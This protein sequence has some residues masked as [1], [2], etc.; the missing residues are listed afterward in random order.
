M[1]VTITFPS[2]RKKNIPLGTTVEE[3]I[4]DE[5]F[6]SADSP[7]I[8]VMVNNDIASLTYR[9]EIDCRLAPIKLASR[10]GADIYRRSLC[11][12]LTI[13]A[14]GLFPDRRLVIGHSLGRGYFY[15]FDNIEEVSDRDLERIR[16][17][18]QEIV[19]TCLPI[20]RQVIPYLEAVQYFEINNQRDT[21]L[22]LKNRNDPKIAVYRCGE[23]IDLAHAPLVPNTGILKVFDILNYPPGFLLRY[24][25]WNKPSEMSPFKDDPVLFAIYREYKNWGKILNVNCVGLLNDLIHERRVKEFI[26]VAEALHDKKIAKIADK[27]SEK[28]EAVKIILIAGPS[29]SGKTTFSKKLSIQLKVLGRN[30]VSISHDD[31]FLPRELTP[32]DEEGNCDFESLNA[33]N[34]AL[35]NEHL[36]RLLQGEE[37]IIPRF[38]FH[39]GQRKESGLAL[40]LPKR[41]I[42]I[43]EGIH[44][45]ND[46]LTHLIEKDRKY[47]IYI[48]TLT[49]LNLDD[50]NR[51]STTDNRL[52]RRIV[53]DY[54]FRGHSA[55]DTLSMWQSVRNG[56]NRNIFPFQNTADSAFNSA[57]DYE[58]AVLKVYAEP[59]LKTVKPDQEVFYEAR[60]LLSFLVDFAPIPSSWVPEYSILREFIGESAFK[61]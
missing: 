22:L 29:S 12:L 49:Q 42:L 20:R 57:L 1:S 28:R 44:G 50:H 13:A 48:S 56:E 53:R 52:I 46:R 3:I 36:V 33:I 24:P 21:V 45:L 27:I 9:I 18:M 17:R 59:L 25:A 60:R 39:T 26:Q 58:C 41:A 15:Y 54:Q 51:I 11:F 30:P 5:E 7:V 40:R 43:L 23:F 34:I 10:E 31:Y 14:R 16:E 55:L 6:Q 38:D 61:Y 32:K 8:A 2:G 37:V 19:Q 4:E 47:K 35:L